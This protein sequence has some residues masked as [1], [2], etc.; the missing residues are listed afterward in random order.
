MRK[1]IVDFIIDL[2]LIILSCF[3]LI[4][5]FLKIDNLKMV[6]IIIFGVITGLKFIQFLII[7]REKDYESLCTSAISLVA[8]LCVIFLPNKTKTFSNILL[9]WMG[10]MCLVKLK[11]A[12]FYED[13]KNKMWILKIFVLFIFLITGL[14]VGL[15]LYE[16]ESKILLVGFFFL[17][18]S[19]LDIMDPIV[20]F[21][22]ESK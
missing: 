2:C 12:D 6:M 21:I 4:F 11:K 8:L 1:L 9:I 19:S 22:L 3:I 20:R 15:N 10:L 13:R 16:A 17:I 18:S 14:I 5:P 7:F